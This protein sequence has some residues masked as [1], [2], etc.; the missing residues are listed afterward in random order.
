MTTSTRDTLDLSSHI[1]SAGLS[2]Y[3]PISQRWCVVWETSGEWTR[4]LP[5]SD[6]NAAFALLRGMQAKGFHEARIQ[7]M[8]E[9]L[10]Q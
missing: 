1:M 2:S 6:Y 9:P 8:G 5:S 10:P 3:T 7:R 4:S